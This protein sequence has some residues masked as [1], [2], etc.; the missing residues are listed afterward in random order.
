PRLLEEPGAQRDL[1]LID[2]VPEHDPREQVAGRRRSRRA[3][4]LADEHRERTEQHDIDQ[5]PQ[6]DVEEAVR[7]PHEHVR[8]AARDRAHAEP[9]LAACAER[10]ARGAHGWSVCWAAAASRSP[11]SWRNTPSRLPRPYCS[12]IAA[13]GPSATMRP[14]ERNSPRSHT[15]S[16]SVMS[17]L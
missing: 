3:V 4:A 17:W 8:V 12:A 16:T 7:A 5:W 9:R 6:R 14:L 15:C 2:D 1:R 11:A 13:G 10:V